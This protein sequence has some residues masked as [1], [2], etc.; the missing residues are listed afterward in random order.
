MKTKYIHVALAAAILSGL[1]GCT[2]N[3]YTELD[4]GSA[5]LA[6]T[7]SSSQLLLEEKNHSLEAISLDWTTGNNY[8]TGNAIN[9]TLELAETGTNFAS[10]YIAVN[11]ERQVYAWNPSVESLNGILLNNFGL[12][13]GEQISLDARI[14]AYVAGSEQ[15]QE[16]V[17]T[18]TA[19]AYEPVSQTLYLIG[20]ATPNGWSAD[21][22]TEMHR[23]DNGKFTWTG[24]LKEG[25]YKFITTLGSFL[26]SYNNNGNGGLVYRSEDSQPDVLFHVDHAHCYRVDADLLA[27]TVSITEEEGVTPQFDHLFFVGNETDWGF[28]PM[29][30][31][32]LDPFLFRIGVFFE[33][34]GEFKFG[35]ADGSWEN[36][37][38]ATQPNAPYTDSKTEL[39]A[40]FDPDNKWFL[41]AEESNKAYKICLDIRTGA[42]RMLMRLFTPYSEMYLVG[43][44]TPNGW[45]LGNATPMTQDA[46]DP[47]IF[48]WT[49]HLNQGELKLSA[50]KQSDWNGAWFMATASGENPTGT[51][52]KVIFI[53][54]SDDACKAEYKDLNAGDVDLKWQ[55]TEAGTYTI[56]LNQ[57]LEEIVIAKD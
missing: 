1:A 22:A 23:S 30:P 48:T 38:K 12:K 7:A 16:A 51:I 10:P 8:G 34:G 57:L 46:A 24:N 47:N 11:D 31:D 28:R 3:N 5:E 40:G 21:N 43:D 4:K 52:Q 19:T 25:D 32:P 45:D 17:A 9:Y 42:E 56:T 54:K 44:A 53:N 35:T 49:G 37:Y 2:D 29:S 15:I 33:K 36:M 50:D 41:T 26:P 27:L 20:D 13:G 18:F 14:T 39:V 55:I 6:I